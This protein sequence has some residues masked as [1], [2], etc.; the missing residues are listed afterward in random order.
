MAREM[1]IRG[2]LAR[3]GFTDPEKAV[4]ITERWSELI[5]ADRSTDLRHL[6]AATGASADPDEA[7][8]V[9]DRLVTDRPAL[10]E[11]LIDEPGLST[12]LA[13]V[14]GVGTGFH[15]HLQKNPDAV[16]ALADEPQRRDADQWRQVLV[17]AIGLPADAADPATTAAADPARGDDLRIAHRTA[18]MQIAARDLTHPEPEAIFE[19]IAAE[20]ADLADATVHAALC[21]A[22]GEVD[23]AEECRLGIVA[24]GKCGAQELNYISD[25]DVLFVAEPAGEVGPDRALSVATRLASAV[26]R[27]C[28]AHTGAGTIWQV[29]AALRP[30]GKAGPLVRTLGSHE[31]YYRRWAKNWEFQAMLKARPMAGDI[32]LA[33]AFCD[34][35][36]PMV[37]QVA[38]REGFV[39]ECQA[40]RRRVIDNIPAKQA[41]REVKLGAGGLRDVEFTVQLLQLVHGRVDERLRTRATL[42]SLQRLIDHGYVN[43]RDGAEFADAYRFERILEHRTQLTRLRRTHLVPESGPDL[44][45]IARGLH[46]SPHD[47]VAAWQARARRVLR[48]HKRLYYSP[49]LEAVARIPGQEVRLTT[50]AARDRLAALGYQDPRSALGHIEALTRGVTRQAEIQRQLLPAMLGWFAE[51]ANPDH[52]L[53][54]FRQVSEELGRSPWYLRGL[55]DEGAMAERFARLLASGRYLVQMILKAPQAV[56]LLSKAENLQPRSAEQ[57]RQEMRR[58]AALHET[59]TEKIAAIRALRRRELLRIG[60]GDALALTALADVG[61]GLTAVTTAVIDTALEVCMGEDTFPLA[62]IAMGR[63]GGGEMSY[64]SDADAMVVIAD[65]APAQRARKVVEELRRELA[66]SGG[67]PALTIDLDLRPEGRDGPIV[68]TLSSYR[69]YYER[70]SKTWEAQALIRAAHG[71]GDVDLGQQFLDDIAP[72]RYPQTFDADQVRQVRRLKARMESERLPR[73]IPR[74]RHLKLGPGGLSDIEWTVQLIQLRHAH[75]H[76]DLQTPQTLTALAAAR[77]AGF[78]DPDDAETLELAWRLASRMRDRVMLVRAKDADIIPQ[79]NQDLMA[80]SMLL[81]GEDGASHLLDHYHRRAFHARKVMDR[82]FWEDRGAG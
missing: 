14:L 56:Q 74:K 50:E 66:K 35:I 13:A 46:L 49:L 38:S 70:W 44:A 24:L 9:I 12:R 47:V 19:E 29:D 61:A 37:W 4:Q 30:E 8:T 62:I 76:A 42:P 32:E 80:V 1:S 58:A 57:L 23:G 6:I 65:D 26:S 59:T 82:V 5:G 72:V 68:R 2:E 27:I 20:L 41:D 55:R 75:D 21:L 73:G 36:D 51:G 34:M 69:G 54:A 16:D 3:S 81:T 7:L 39:S 48:L 31:T 17:T 53:L 40:M 63:W 11:R 60:A 33:T 52:A 45:R 28:S 25:V 22:R 15:Q 64:A 18:V 78:I 77:E 43:R 79:S 71:A 10:L 67:E